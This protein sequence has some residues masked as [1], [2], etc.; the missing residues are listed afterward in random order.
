[1]KDS[2]AAILF[3]AILLAT[4]IGVG[5]ISF[6]DLCGFE[7]KYLLNGSQLAPC[8]CLGLVNMVEENNSNK[9]YCTG[10]NLSYQHKYMEPLYHRG[11]PRVYAGRA[12]VTINHEK[13]KLPA[14][15]Q[16][17]ESDDDCILV[18][19][20]CDINCSG[21]G[22]DF[23]LAINRRHLVSWLTKLDCE[24]TKGDV[25]QGQCPLAK[26]VCADRIC[27]SITIDLDRYYNQ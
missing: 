22:T 21:G 3:F 1:M 10:V 27:T 25:Y 11:I 7:E 17:C 14:D 16:T 26:A 20:S 2:H 4:F 23:D 9:Y 24:H 19:N 12:V 8:H 6:K 5:L 13:Y 18:K 15:L